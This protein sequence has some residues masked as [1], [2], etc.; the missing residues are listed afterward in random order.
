M[1]DNYR[2]KIF[3]LLCFYRRRIVMEEIFHALLKF[4]MLFSF[5]RG[6]SEYFYLCAGFVMKNNINFAFP[7][8]FCYFA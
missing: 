1:K 6:F 7:L 3:L 5:T 2:G 4:Q 8:S